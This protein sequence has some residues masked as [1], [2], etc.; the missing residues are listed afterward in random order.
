MS[1][2]LSSFPFS[3]CGIFVPCPSCHSLSFLPFSYITAVI[4][5]LYMKRSLLFCLF[6]S[7]L[8]DFFF[9]AGFP[10]CSISRDDNVFVDTHR[11]EGKKRK[12]TKNKPVNARLRKDREKKMPRWKSPF[13]SRSL[14]LSR[15][16]P[17]WRELL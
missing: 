17:S 13:L 1:S 9:L 16:L 11:G 3:L 4:C 12:A 5:R 14:S 8:A 15:S 6:P 7:F 2:F 10:S